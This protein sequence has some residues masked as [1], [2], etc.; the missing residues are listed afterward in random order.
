MSIYTSELFDLSHTLAHKLLSSCKYPW[1]ALPLIKQTVEE[2]G[3][4]LPS[5]E[6]HCPEAG[7]WIANSATVASSATLLPPCIIGKNSEIRTGAFIRGSVIVGE[8]CVVGNSC[9]LK[10]AILFDSVQVP[11]FNYIGDSI[12]G[13]RSHTGAGAITSNVKSDKSL[14]KVKASQGDIETGLK[15]FGAMLG[16]F[17]EVGCNCVLNP[18]TV[19]GRRTSIYPLSSVRGVVEEDCIYKNAENVVK[20]K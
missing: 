6:Y 7:V 20:R 3:A 11:H 16:D 19:I 15:K 18:G 4:S 13:Y 12:L 17:V 9:E 2:I 5:D 14:V 8:G 1:E 10:N